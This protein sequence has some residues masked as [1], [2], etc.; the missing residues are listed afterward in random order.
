VLDKIGIIL[1]LYIPK[2]GLRLAYTPALLLCGGDLE[3]KRA[4]VAGLLVLLSFFAYNAYTYHQL[5]SAEGAYK[6]AGISNSEKLIAIYH[7]ENSWQFATYNEKTNTLKLYTV[8][9]SSP[10][11]V[12]RRTVESVK[13]L[14]NCTPLTLNLNQ[15]K[16]YKPHS[17]ALPFKTLGWKYDDNIK[18]ITYSKLSDV[19]SPNS[20]YTEITGTLSTDGLWISPK[21]YG[22]GGDAFYGSAGIK[23]LLVLPGNLNQPTISGGYIWYIENRTTREVHYPGIIVKSPS[24]ELNSKTFTGR[25]LLNSIKNSSVVD[26]KSSGT[27]LYGSLEFYLSGDGK[28]MEALKW[29][30][31]R[32]FC[33]G[34]WSLK[35]KE[36]RPYCIEYYNVIS[37]TD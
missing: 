5:S 1:P 17:K 31:D 33:F 32:Q 36:H 25:A 37:H 30:T 29:V 24:R 6:L 11:W 13:A 19:I 34:Y 16:Q 2:T 26:I 18:R 35:D 14:I 23:G 10:F 22:N 21:S 8:G 3:M 27:P 12:K 4:L 7:D 20:S 9:Q 15:L 28:L